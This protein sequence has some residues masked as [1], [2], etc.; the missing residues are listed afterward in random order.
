MRLFSFAILLTGSGSAATTTSTTSKS[1]TKMANRRYTFPLHHPRLY[2]RFATTI[3]LLLAL[4]LNIA[5]T[6]KS[7]CRRN[8]ED[9][10]DGGWMECTSIAGLSGVCLYFYTSTLL[11][12]AAAPSPSLSHPTLVLSLV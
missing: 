5:A 6:T 9:D 3:V 7:S 4:L 10:D 11:V 1:T 12:L 2:T 8:Y